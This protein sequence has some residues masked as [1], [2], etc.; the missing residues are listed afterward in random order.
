MTKP[1]V[2]NYVTCRFGVPGAWAAG[3]HTGIDF[4]APVGTP[5]YA[6]FRGRVI[7]E[8]MGGGYG[9]AYGKHVI[10]ESRYKGKTIRH[11]YAH[12]NKSWV[13]EGQR[14]RTAFNIGES[15]VTGN[16]TG[17]HLH[18]E[19]RGYPFGYYNYQEP[20]LTKFEPRGKKWRKRIAA[21]FKN[22]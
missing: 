9:P 8:G 3:R 22:K 14:V 16:V 13:N 20:V 2:L 10:I 6:T 18:Y 17:P 21:R 4:R 5:I 7:Y 11:L 19:E 15:G 12:L 1:T